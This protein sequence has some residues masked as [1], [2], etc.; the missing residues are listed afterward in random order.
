MIPFPD[1]KYQII[2]A[3][4]PWKYNTTQH[5]G[6]KGGYRNQ[7]YLKLHNT[8]YQKG[9]KN[10]YV[11]MDLKELKLLPIK[12]ITDENCVLFLWVCSPFLKQ[13]IELGESWGFKYKTIAFIWYKQI[14]NPGFYTKHGKK[15]K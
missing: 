9:A 12:N 3:D 4:P 14:H 5:Q 1:K 7:S 13:G 2:Y 11:C 15:Q 6:S 10:Q 8:V